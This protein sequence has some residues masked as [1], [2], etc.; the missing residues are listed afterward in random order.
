VLLHLCDQGPGGLAVALGDLDRDCAVDRGE[1]LGEDRVDDDA[2]DL[3]DLADV[4]R[5]AVPA[6]RRGLLLGRGGLAA[7]LLLARLLAGGRLALSLRH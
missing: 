1:V 3:D 7:G 2:F 6:L 4:A 5:R